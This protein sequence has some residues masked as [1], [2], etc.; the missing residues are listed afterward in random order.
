TLGNL[1]LVTKQLNPAL[2]HGP[3]DKKR[4]AL[5]K[6]TVLMLNKDLLADYPGPWNESTIESRGSK[7]ADLA[8]EVWGPPDTTWQGYAEASQAAALS[9]GEAGG[10]ELRADVVAFLD[11][12]VSDPDIRS[13]AM[14]VLTT[15]SSLPDVVASVGRSSQT[16]DG[17]GYAV[18]LRRKG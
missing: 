4:E 3:W 1:T 16:K 9:L 11:A 10:A 7:L 6:H 14:K 2:S 8:M 18:I 13:Q 17:W 12:R 5:E 15:L